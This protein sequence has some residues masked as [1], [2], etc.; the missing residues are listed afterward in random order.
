[1]ASLPLP[2]GG[3]TAP[4][5]LYPNVNNNNKDEDK[6]SGVRYVGAARQRDACCFASLLFPPDR[7]ELA[8]REDSKKVFLDRFL[9]V[10]RDCGSLIEPHSWNKHVFGAASAEE[11]LKGGDLESE[12]VLYFTADRRGDGPSPC[13]ASSSSS[14]LDMGR[15]NDSGG[16]QKNSSS[17][18][19]TFIFGIVAS[20][21]FPQRTALKCLDEVTE[22]FQAVDP[23]EGLRD[24]ENL[25][26]LFPQLRDDFFRLQ[27]PL[28]ANVWSKYHEAGVGE[29]ERESPQ[30]PSGTRNDSVASNFVQKEEGRRTEA[31]RQAG[32]FGGGGPVAR[33]CMPS[34]PSY[35]TTTSTVVAPVGERGGEGGEHGIHSVP[36][37]EK[38]LCKEKKERNAQEGEDKRLKEKGTLEVPGGNSSVSSSFSSPPVSPSSAQAAVAFASSQIRHEVFLQQKQKGGVGGNVKERRG[39]AGPSLSRYRDAFALDLPGG[40]DGMSSDSRHILQERG[41]RGALPSGSMTARAGYGSLSGS[42][43]SSARGR[44]KEG[45]DVRDVP[46]LPCCPSSKKFYMVSMGQPET[47]QESQ[48]GNED[49]HTLSKPVVGLASSRGFGGRKTQTSSLSSF[50]VS[51]K[52]AQDLEIDEGPRLAPVLPSSSDRVWIQQRPHG[53]DMH[54]AGVPLNVH[55]S[56]VNER[57]EEHF[58][59]SHPSFPFQPPHPNCTPS[60][61][62]RQPMNRISPGL[63]GVGEE[64]FPQS[65]PP[66]S[67]AFQAPHR[68]MGTPAPLFHQHE[69]QTGGF[70]GHRRP[71]AGVSVPLQHQHQQQNLQSLQGGGVRVGALLSASGRTLTDPLP[72]PAAAMSVDGGGGRGGMSHAAPV[73]CPPSAS[74]LPRPRPSSWLG[75]HPHRRGAPSHSSGSGLFRSFSSRELAP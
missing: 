31:Q 9:E 57:R 36:D 71:S 42:G 18:E 58:G 13:Q 65:F 63:S 39:D 73:D 26:G 29:G 55:L 44:G 75:S 10:V 72:P 48:C 74:V 35:S 40:V 52:D 32:C 1:M 34:L 38:S 70:L 69:N 49:T 4:V 45:A 47:A 5:P 66:P 59:S 22:E 61:P 28:F 21:D 25:C 56:T 54:A 3:G 67:P 12:W 23:R 30:A 20:A 37:R 51:S 41:L 19:E 14:S 17:N 27:G 7:Q 53:V 15:G 50:S 24:F 33:S 11:E 64:A 6:F 8:R 46:I 68:P 62:H 16:G 60:L 2:R 43:S